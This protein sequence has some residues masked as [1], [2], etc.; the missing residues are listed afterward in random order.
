[1]S[2]TDPK[3]EAGKTKPQLHLIPRVAMEEM[4]KAL[5]VGKERYGERNWVQV[6]VQQST[7]VSALLRHAIAF[8][9]GEDVALDSGVHH[10]AHILANCA[11]I[12]DAAKAGTLVDDRVKIP[13]Q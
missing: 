13:R 5:Q 6:P 7:Y 11:I 3:G 8:Q 4:A 10:M 1:M 12:L 2:G 9:D